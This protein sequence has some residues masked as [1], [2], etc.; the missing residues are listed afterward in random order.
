MIEKERI[1]NSDSIAN[2][3]THWAINFRSIKHAFMSVTL[4]NEE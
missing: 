1:L 3:C 4:W 2:D